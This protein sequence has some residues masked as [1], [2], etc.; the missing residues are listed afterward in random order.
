MSVTLLPRLLRLNIL[1]WTVVETVIQLAQFMVLCY[2][3]VLDTAD[4]SC[5]A[6]DPEV[7][8]VPLYAFQGGF[9]VFVEYSFIYSTLYCRG[10]VSLTSIIG[11]VSKFEPESWNKYAVTVSRWKGVTV[12]MGSL[13]PWQLKVSVIAY[14]YSTLRKMM[15]KLG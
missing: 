2:D 1:G 14:R 3:M 7:T 10:F 15:L 6:S 11:C 5:R 13:F 12:F 9:F 8:S 4:E